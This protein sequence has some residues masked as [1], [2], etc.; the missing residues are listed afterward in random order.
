MQAV[1]QRVQELVITHS[2][3]PSN[4][5]HWS[6]V[7]ETASGERQARQARIDEYELE[8]ASSMSKLAQA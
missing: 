6:A 3:V 2:N 4:A 5:A 1:L 8:L 7:L